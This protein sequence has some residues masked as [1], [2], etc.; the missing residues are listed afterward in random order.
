MDDYVNAFASNVFAQTHPQPSFAISGLPGMEFAIGCSFGRKTN[1][2]GLSNATSPM[3]Q[4]AR[5]RTLYAIKFV[6]SNVFVS[7]CRLH[8]LTDCT[9]SDPVIHGRISTIS[10]PVYG[11]GDPQL[12]YL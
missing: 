5:T 4:L 11:T 1:A 9:D 6:D 3:A 2:F 10:N 8:T 7:S 12:F